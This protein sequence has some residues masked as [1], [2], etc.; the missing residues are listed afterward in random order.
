MLAPQHPQQGKLLS[1]SVVVMVSSS[2]LDISLHMSS[3][4]E[5]LRSMTRTLSLTELQTGS[6]PFHE[7]VLWGLVPNLPEESQRRSC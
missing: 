7:A 1:L 6:P 2:H 5:P 3:A 4:D